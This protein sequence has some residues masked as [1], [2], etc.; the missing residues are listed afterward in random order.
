MLP[1]YAMALGPANGSQSSQWL[2][3]L[4]GSA[5]I[6]F[7]FIPVLE[8]SNLLAFGAFVFS[9]AAGRRTVLWAA[10]AIRW[11]VCGWPPWVKVWVLDVWGPGNYGSRICYF[12]S[13]VG[14]IASAPVK[15][16]LID[17]ES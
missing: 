6:H 10:V 5:T 9:V 17:Y 16:C 2:P 15:I 11:L 3:G 12:V 14:M 8:Y 1:E 4:M 7:G 13:S